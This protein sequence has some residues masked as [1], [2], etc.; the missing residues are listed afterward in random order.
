MSRA[1]TSRPAPGGRG[2]GARCAVRRR[3]PAPPRAPGLSPLTQ[4]KRC[5]YLGGRCPVT[6]RRSPGRFRESPPPLCP[7]GPR[8]RE[9]GRDFPRQAAAGAR[10]APGL[11][12]ERPRWAGRA[13]APREPPRSLPIGLAPG[14]RRAHA[15][16]V[17][18]EPGGGL[19]LPARRCRRGPPTPARKG[20]ARLPVSPPGCQAGSGATARSGP[21]GA[22]AGPPGAAAALARGSLPRRWPGWEVAG[23]PRGV[24]RSSELEAPRAAEENTGRVTRPQGRGGRHRHFINSFI[25]Y[26]LNSPA[27]ETWPGPWQTDDKQTNTMGRCW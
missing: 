9:G 13:P 19:L 22:A 16:P 3:G 11:G 17:C 5:P 23:A 8:R 21:A 10:K 14:P 18:H 27:L 4:R 25:K 15:R 24:W 20:G 26:I 6:R 7:A 2:P 12:P 1:V